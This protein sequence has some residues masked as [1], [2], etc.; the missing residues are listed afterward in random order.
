MKTTRVKAGNR[1]ASRWRRKAARF[2]A[3]SRRASAKRRGDCDNA[4]R[5][6]DGEDADERRWNPVG[7]G[8]VVAVVVVAAKKGSRRAAEIRRWAPDE[9][10]FGRRKA[11]LRSSRGKRERPQLRGK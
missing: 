6:W 4:A 9:R 11:S 10:C 8:A 7:A 2:W 3:A 1:R 5:R